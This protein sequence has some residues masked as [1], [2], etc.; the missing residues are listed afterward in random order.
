MGLGVGGLTA[1]TIGVFVDPLSAALGWSRAQ[2]SAWPLCMVIGAMISMPIVGRFVDAYGVRRVASV[3]IVVLTVCLASLGFIGGSVWTLYLAALSTALLGMG[4]SGLTYTKAVNS[5]FDAGRG[6]ALGLIATGPAVA[7]IVGPKL[8]QVAVD[9]YGWRAGFWFIAAAALIVLP[10]AYCLLPDDKGARNTGAAHRPQTRDH[11]FRMPP[12]FWI[13]GIAFFLFGV[14]SGGVAFHLVP[15][16][17]DNAISRAK[18]VEFAGLFGIASLTGRL[19]TGFVLDRFP[20]LKICA[21][22]FLTASSGLALFALFRVAQAALAVV[23]VGF[24]FGGEM[25]V[26][27]YCTARFF[28]QKRYGEIYGYFT[29][30]AAGGVSLG[31]LLL[32]YVREQSGTYDAG[33]LA[34]AAL[35]FLATGL[36]LFSQRFSPRN[37]EELS[38]PAMPA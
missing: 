12:F 19:V 34:A 20:P 1:S 7:T 37:V 31:P 5:S 24:A 27:P 10:A 15:F 14:S 21:L 18:A 33:F 9:Q 32:G 17:S 13:F 22:L 16:L 35:S 8:L 26:M 28:G 6:L 4:T 36:I 2:L 3:S 11:D 38:P 25:D 30:F 29:W 23:L